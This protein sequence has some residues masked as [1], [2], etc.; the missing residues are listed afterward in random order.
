MI[1]VVVAT[2][3]RPPEEA[4]MKIAL[5]SFAAKETTRKAATEDLMWALINSAEFVFN[6]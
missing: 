1:S 4:E 6:H 3:N 2:Y 5:D